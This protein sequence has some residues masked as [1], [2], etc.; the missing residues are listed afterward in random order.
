MTVS[1]IDKARKRVAKFR[2]R[3]PEIA[4]YVGV[5]VK[6]VSKFANYANKPEEG[7]GEPGAV[8][9]KRLQEWLDENEEQA[10]QG[11]SKR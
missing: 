3:Y 6:W 7:I 8:K 5:H 2:G 10:H 1:E 11:G 4:E 9:F